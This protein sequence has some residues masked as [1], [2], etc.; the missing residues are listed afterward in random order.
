MHT[1]HA[2]DTVRAAEATGDPTT[3]VLRPTMALSPDRE[4]GGETIYPK[5]PKLSGQ[6]G[7][8]CEPRRHMAP[9]L[10][11]SFDSLLMPGQV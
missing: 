5:L 8:P 10:K 1:V 6:A 11:K 4:T 3:K 2:T 9:R 7:S